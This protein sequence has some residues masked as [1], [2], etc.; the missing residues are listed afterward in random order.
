MTSDTS[1]KNPYAPPPEVQP[2]QPKSVFKAPAMQAGSPEQHDQS[3]LWSDLETPEGRE[4]AL[5]IYRQQADEFRRGQRKSIDPLL[6]QQ[7]GTWGLQIFADPDPVEAMARLLGRPKPGK[8]ADANIAERDVQITKEVIQLMD[9]KDMS[10][11]AA[12]IEI[13][14]KY[15]RDSQTIKGIYYANRLAVQLI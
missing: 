13:G 15:Y 14:K 5:V 4:I 6:V 12:A 11:N 2:Q 3:W 9:S 8:R 10:L 1:T 7:V